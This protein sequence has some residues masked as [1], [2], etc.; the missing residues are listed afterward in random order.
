MRT[1]AL[2]AAL[3]AFGALALAPT[4][5]AV[6]ATLFAHF[7]GPGEPF[8]LNTQEPPEAFAWDAGPGTAAAT[9][10]CLPPVPAVMR[11]EPHTLHGYPAPKAVEYQDDGSVRLPPERGVDADV[12]ILSGRMVLH[13]YWSAEAFGPDGAVPAVVPDVVVRATLRAGDASVG[14][15]LGP[16]IAEGESP[17]ALLAGPASQGVEHG[18]VGGRTVYHFVVDMAVDPGQAVLPA[19]TSFSLVVETFALGEACDSGRLMPGGVRLHSS[20]GHRP[21]LELDAGTPLALLATD[22]RILVSEGRPTLSA[23]AFHVELL[24]A[25]G[26][27]DLRSV[28]AEAEGPGLARTAMERMAV[29][30][31]EHRLGD[32]GPWPLGFYAPREPLEDRSFEAGTYT[33]RLSATTLQGHGETWERTYRLGE[34]PEAP[35]PAP[36]LLLAGL[37]AAA[38]ALRRRA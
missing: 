23:L 36:A 9:T 33:F 32:T 1:P 8:A 38:V 6:P 14:L 35:G 3:A 29:L 27:Y 17:P 11:E 37:L 24:D 22:A 21:R 16:V 30:Q 15:P 7:I 19:A 28:E 20:P 25:W 18:Q 5:A 10:T 2:L 4:A 12:P 13:W 31:T 34:G 26:R